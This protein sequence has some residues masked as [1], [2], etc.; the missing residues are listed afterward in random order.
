MFR[1]LVVPLDGSPLAERALPYA[2]RLAQASNGQLVL[3]RAAMAP[4]ARSLDGAEWEGDQIAAV[5][6]ALQYLHTIAESLAGQVPTLNVLAPYGRTVEKILETA[7]SVHADAIVMATHGRTGLAH[8]L[9]G[10]VTEEVL[11]RS[12]VPVFAVYARPG[13]AASP[14]FSPEAARVL[15][16]QDG[17]EYDAPALQT[18]LEL[19]GP[20]G[21][22]VLTAV[23]SPPEHLELD[24][25]GRHVLAYLDQQEEA[26]SREA[27]EYLRQVAEPHARTGP[28]RIRTEVRLGD[29][30]VCIVRTAIETDADLIVMATHGRT[31]I[32]RAVVGSV[33]GAV[34]RTAKAPV[35]LVHPQFAMSA[36]ATAVGPTPTF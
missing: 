33:A 16:P 14:A 29:P 27:R 23:A 24:Q 34:L 7:E 11:S 20:Q 8:L 1:T 35:V 13:L 4:A 31:G 28:I 22:I 2:V 19:L 18:A 5:E 9:F 25:S 10:S 3:T 26:R 12:N 30:A 36:V 6:E 32:T 15:V 21:E 17:S